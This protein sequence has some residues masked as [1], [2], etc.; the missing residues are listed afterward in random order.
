VLPARDV[1]KNG[2]KIFRVKK[3]I[4]GQNKRGLIKTGQ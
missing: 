4:I 3:L 1:L 2:E